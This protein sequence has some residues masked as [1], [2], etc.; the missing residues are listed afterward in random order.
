MK[1]NSAKRVKAKEEI[2]VDEKIKKTKHKG[3]YGMTAK[4]LGILIPVVFIGFG[5]LVFMSYKDSK[6]SLN[7]E[8]EVN[9]NAI[10]AQAALSLENTIE[11]KRVK[12]EQLASSIGFATAD[13]QERVDDMKIVKESDK[14]FQMVAYADS[15]GK[16]I[17]Q[18]GEEMDRSSRDYFKSV[19]STGEPFMTA[20]F[21]SGTTGQLIVVIAY[22]VKDQGKV[23]GVLYG[24]ISL[25]SISDI[26]GK[27]SYKKTGYVYVADEEGLCIG[28]KQ[29][30]DRVGAMDLTKS[31]DDFKI[32][33]KLISAF[34]SCIS[35]K[36]QL[37]TYYTTTSGVYN[38][39]IFTPVDLKNRTWVTVTCV[40]VSEIEEAS[41][42]LLR[43]MNSVSVGI[44]IVVVII[45]IVLVKRI[46]KPIKLVTKSLERMSQLDFTNDMSLMK[47]KDRNDET[48]DMGRSLIVLFEHLTEV[49]KDIQDQSSE[50]FLAS[51]TLQNNAGETTRT[52]GHIERAVTEIAEGATDQATETQNATDNVVTIG[53]MIKE[54]KNGV[55][56]IKA[57]A[58]TISEANDKATE[59]LNLLS[60]INEKTIASI[61]MIAQQ[62]KTTNESAAKIKDAATLISDIAD[63]TNLLSLNASI[64]AARAGDAGKG[65]AVVASEI[66]QLAEQSNTSA[67]QIDQVVKQLIDDSD[68]SVNTMAEVSEIISKQSEYIEST[69]DIFKN[70]NEGVENSV[71]GIK[72]ISDKTDELDT[73]RASI[74][75]TVQNL[76][77][78]AEEN[79]AGTEQTSAAVT[80]ADAIMHE[81]LD[82]ADKLKEV[83]KTL[84]KHMNKFI[85]D[86]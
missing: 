81:I 24:T 48:G 62:T 45:I 53:D 26:V 12:I 14:L 61:K 40:P 78:I 67:Q 69:R 3:F 42:I 25:E 50:L 71:E 33:S 74:I 46:V 10:S 68:K 73:A 5:L 41:M 28:F 11:M 37:S 60:E 65:F 85:V 75:D 13:T 39:A 6:A 79:A 59:A 27:F 80:E 31:T 55:E 77:A 64:E 66:Q 58:T 2:V 57:G 44:I 22:P 23:T 29:K 72:A 36:K 19:M 9:A 52:F 21:K 4:F 43:N 18:D 1:I 76:T 82:S 63:Q 51:E 15:T 17:S 34:G 84:D 38:K 83:A 30:P 49:I 7:E 20:P 16:A 70:V 47:V 32:D 8:A 54:T 35:S 56:G 86:K